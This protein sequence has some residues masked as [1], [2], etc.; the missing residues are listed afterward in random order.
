MHTQPSPRRLKI[1]CSRSE[2]G[3][4]SSRL[5]FCHNMLKILLSEFCNNLI[6]IVCLSVVSSVTAATCPPLW[7]LRQGKITMRVHVLTS[8][9]EWKDKGGTKWIFSTH[10]QSHKHAHENAHTVGR[11][12]TFCLISWWSIIREVKKHDITPSRPRYDLEW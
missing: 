2:F 8:I 4:I 11:R 1:F 5:Q 6:K 7:W 10:R 12:L 3:I 9:H